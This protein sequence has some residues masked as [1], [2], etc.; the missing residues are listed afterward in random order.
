MSAPA[1]RALGATLV[2]LVAFGAACVSLHATRTRHFDGRL[3]SDE[4]EWIAVSVLHWRQLTRG[5]RPDGWERTPGIDPERAPWHAGFHQATFGAVNPDLPKLLWGAA[6][7]ATG[8]RTA[9]HLV[10]Q[11]FHGDD[12]AAGRRA[13]AELLP[14][15][16]VARRVLLGATALCAVLLAYA[17]WRAG[18]WPAGAAAYV[19]WLAAPLVQRWANYLRT[20]FFMVAASLGALAG[21]LALQRRLSGRAGARAQVAAGAA[22]GVLVAL[23]ASCKL[24]GGLVALAVPFWVLVPWWRARREHGV[25]LLRGPL[26]ALVAAGFAC[27]AVFVALKPSLWRD[28]LGELRAMADF[29]GPHMAYQQERAEGGGVAVARTLWEKLA[30]A[31]E[32]L[33]VRDEPLSAR[34]GLPVAALLVP[35]GVAALALPRFLGERRDAALAVLVWVA[36]TAA[37]TIAW[38]PLDWE[39]YFFPLAAAAILCEAAAVAAVARPLLRRAR[40][41]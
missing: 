8:H 7:D 41:R 19:L 40:S 1:R 11:R 26:P 38:L 32:R 29:W 39:R 37:G 16:P 35:A 17:G 15:L 9:S 18:G 36:V 6:L 33:V 20:D 4:P 28:P 25:S 3:E 2:L 27:L 24:N 22:L 10:F 23:A 21:A 34:S 13:R 5:G 12:P 31:V 14:A 30:L